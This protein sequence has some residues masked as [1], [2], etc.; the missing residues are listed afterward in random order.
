MWLSAP[1]N[2]MFGDAAA[3]RDGQFVVSYVIPNALDPQ[4]PCATSDEGLYVT[5]VQSSTL[6]QPLPVAVP[7]VGGAAFVRFGDD[8][9]LY[10]IGA[11]DVALHSCA[12]DGSDL[13]DDSRVPC[14]RAAVHR[15]RNDA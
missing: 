13:R 9:R 3:S 10:F 6:G 5:S 1:P 15:L 2:C 11:Q 8:G 7:D 12:L 4:N 14:G